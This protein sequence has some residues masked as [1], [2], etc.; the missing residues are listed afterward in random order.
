LVRV[1]RNRIRDTGLRPYRV[2]GHHTV[3]VNFAERAEIA[4]NILERVGGSGL[5]IFGGKASTATYDVPFTRILMYNNKAAD[6]LLCAND[7]GG[8]ETWQGGTFY[9][10]N[11]VSH[12]PLARQNFA[13][14]RF[15]AAYYL[16]GAFK[17]YIFNNIAWGT[18]SWVLNQY[19]DA[20]CAFQQV[21]GH[22]NTFFNNSAS[23]TKPTFHQQSSST[24]R[25][26]FLGN[27][28]DFSKT[29][30][31][32]NV[33]TTTTANYDTLAYDWNVITRMN[34]NFGRFEN[35]GTVYATLGAF[36]G[37]LNTRKAMAWA[38]GTQLVA[39]VVAD[40]GNRD[41]RPLAGSAA[42]DAAGSMFVPWTLA[43]TE[44]EWHFSL[45]RNTPDSVYNE[46]WYM[47]AAYV[48]RD[49][50]QYMPTL[51]LT[52][53]NVGAADYV[54]SPLDT[55][56]PG[57]LRLD[58]A[59]Q[60]AYA[61]GSGPN[62]MT[63]DIGTNGFVVELIFRSV[64]GH[65]GG[66]L[67]AKAAA[68]GY[69]LDLDAAGRARATLLQAGVFV[70]TRTSGVVVNDGAWHH[71]LLEFVRPA[72]AQ[73]NLFVDGVPA[74]GAASGALPL[75]AVTLT[76]V[77]QF[78]VGRGASGAYFAGD[79]DFLRV[80]HGSLADA[81]TS[82]AELYDWQFGGPAL[83]DFR[84]LPPNG[85]RDAGALEATYL[86]ENL[87]RI[88]RQLT[89]VV[90]DLGA[91]GGLRVAA[92]GADYYQWAKDSMPFAAGTN[93]ALVFAAADAPDAGVYTLSVS[94]AAGAVT[95][96]PITVTVIPEPIV[97]I[98]TL[99]LCLCSWPFRAGRWRCP[100]PGLL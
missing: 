40:A 94:N 75:A 70:F 50:Y 80:A 44:G 99:L 81:F 60:Y 90:L 68:D 14:S 19:V 6:T 96:A 36:A 85:R 66:V 42:L 54:A 91:G 87:P 32:D 89:N 88:T 67:V 10:Y 55:W 29:Y 74:N 76:N 33:A 58:G 15:G 46:A 22:F 24:G 3:N 100:R 65:T 57:A 84:G 48:G 72:P 69:V 64:P 45:N 41:F 86:D 26:K 95:S 7:W 82:I 52:C 20:S 98:A 47:R 27:I 59:T 38:T 2:N 77:A 97:G 61:P 30:V 34:N 79:I 83:A 43:R 73:L 16:D 92:L 49:S 21:L 9:V 25:E 12:N 4:G 63:F 5:F 17:N 13:I 35:G 71:L 18:Q 56:A 37:A 1:L 28:I 11:N 31:F 8:I 53:V 62:G 51:P 23:A 93:P 78:L 39:S